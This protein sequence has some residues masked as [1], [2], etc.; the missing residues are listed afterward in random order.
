[1]IIWGLRSRNKVLGQRVLNCPNCHR[2]AMTAA[3]QSRRWFTLFFIP[4]FPIS[5]KKT[6][7]QCGLCG[8]RYQVDNAHA[9]QLYGGAGSAQAPVQV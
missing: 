6:M 1:M 7:A 8:F 2:D 4:I 5:E 9:E 3:A